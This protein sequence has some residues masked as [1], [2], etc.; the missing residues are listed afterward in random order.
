MALQCLKD[1]FED[2]L[3]SFSL[4]LYEIEANPEALLVL[5]FTQGSPV[6]KQAAQRF[7]TI[8]INLQMWLSYGLQVVVFAFRSHSFRIVSELFQTK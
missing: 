2:C 7:T 4:I 5:S 6:Q 1:S 3:I 8:C